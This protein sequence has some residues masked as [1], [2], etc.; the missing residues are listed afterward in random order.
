LR[1]R[2]H[3]ATSTPPSEITCVIVAIV[4]IKKDIKELKLYICCWFD[5]KNS[6]SA[7][8][9]RRLLLEKNDGLWN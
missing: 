5:F 1:E 3:G 2:G 7:T 9:L 4:L 6:L 8:S